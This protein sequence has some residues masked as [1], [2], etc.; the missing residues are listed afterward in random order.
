MDDER[1]A[2]AED[3]AEQAGFE[4]DIVSGRILSG[5]GRPIVPGGHECGKS[6]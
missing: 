5:G 4:H 3:A 2:H 1:A 6:T